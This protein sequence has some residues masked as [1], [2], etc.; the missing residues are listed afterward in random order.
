MRKE[1]LSILLYQKPGLTQADMSQAVLIYLPD[2]MI[3]NG[4]KATW[5]L[6]SVQLDLEAKGIV[7]RNVEKKITHLRSIFWLCILLITGKGL[8]RNM[9]SMLNKKHTMILIKALCLSFY[10]ELP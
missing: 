3:P 7:L 5:W 8:E 1:L 10:R 9:W 6:K 2:D 4:A